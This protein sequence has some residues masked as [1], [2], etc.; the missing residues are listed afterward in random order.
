MKSE[1]AVK[2]ALECM[3][4]EV[5]RLAVSANLHDVHGLDWPSAKGASKRRQEL[6]E[7]MEVLEERQACMKQSQ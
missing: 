6:K 1:K 5:Q 7:A 2:L 3:R 4:R